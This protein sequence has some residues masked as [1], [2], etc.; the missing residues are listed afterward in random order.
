[1]LL[2]GQFIVSLATYFYISAGFGCGPRDSL[3]VALGKKF[4]QMPIGA[5]RGTIE[6]VVLVIGWLMG[7]KVGIGT[8]I[9]VFGMGFVLQFTFKIL[10]FEIRT[11]KHESIFDTF[12][13][14]K[15]PLLNKNVK[16]N[17]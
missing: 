6:A 12:S 10:K 9:A 7:A 15:N 14:L 11:V 8:V 17:E 1:M 13:I 16:S 3:M 2:T 4:P 5:I